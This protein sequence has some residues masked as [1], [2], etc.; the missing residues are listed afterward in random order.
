MVSVIVHDDGRG[1]PKEVRGSL[2]REGV[3]FGDGKGTGLGLFLVRRSMHRFG[4]TIKL[5]QKV[6]TGAGFI[7]TFP[8]GSREN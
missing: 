6:N 8:N 7:L 2:F 4:G 3:T 5:D 1:I